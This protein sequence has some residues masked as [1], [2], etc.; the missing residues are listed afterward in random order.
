MKYLCLEWS[1]E[2]L[3]NEFK[4]VSG[5]ILEHK[6]A[7]E[8]YEDFTGNRVEDF[9]VAEADWKA[10]KQGISAFTESEIVL[11]AQEILK[12]YQQLIQQI[13]TEHFLVYPDGSLEYK[14][15]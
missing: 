2:N 15:N 8:N 14:V 9:R 10:L 3:L 4:R 1:D 5:L 13:G 6:L 12:F 11:K 7:L